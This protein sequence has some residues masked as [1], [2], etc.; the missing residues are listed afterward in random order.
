MLLTGYMIGFESFCRPYLMQFIAYSYHSRVCQS[1]MDVER[2][3]R[4][5]S[6]EPNPT[7]GQRAVTYTGTER[8]AQIRLSQIYD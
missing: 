7:Y 1:L 5:T 3:S 8:M 4:R 6:I 2:R